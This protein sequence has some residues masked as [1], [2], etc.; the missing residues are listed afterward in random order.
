MNHSSLTSPLTTAYGPC[1][2]D[3]IFSSDFDQ[4]QEARRFDDPSIS[5][6]EWVTDVKEA[7]WH[8]VIR[9]CEDILGNKSKDLRATCWLIEAR[10]KIS[11]L[12][13]LADGY[14]LLGQL[15]ESFW[16][17][18]HPQPE[19]GDME[20]RTGVLDW[21]ANQTPRLLR[22][23]ALTHS[24]RGN[25]S[26]VDHESARATA[27]QIER[28]P[29][30]AD[31]ITRNANVSLDIFDAAVKETPKA[32]F[33]DSLRNTQYLRDAIKRVQTLL[34]ARMGEFSPAFGQTFDVLDDLD[35]FFQR[36]AGSGM[37]PAHEPSEGGQ[38]PVISGQPGMTLPERREPTIGGASE[39]HPGPIC[40]REQAIR[41]LQDIA[42]FFRRTEPHSP[43]AYLAEKAA[44][45][46]TM[47]L[48]EWLRTV[49]KDDSALLR[50]EELLGVE[51]PGNDIN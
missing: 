12:P 22:E 34:D 11:G 10:S 8:E 21:L 15:C 43:V 18:I 35:H 41:Q 17:D 36:H 40:S 28:N 33:A 47:P 19:D 32:W 2:E 3:L 4:I 9:I 46:G 16:D 42:A 27:K 14:M 24:A 30:L 38:V 25:F 7:D 37:K 39:G 44:K 5:Q 31:E 23:V 1:G 13:G 51:A 48:H 49:V 29:G 26:L 20:Q 50:M 6:G 45:W